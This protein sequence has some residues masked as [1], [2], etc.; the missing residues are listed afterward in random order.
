ML[1]TEQLMVTVDF[2]TMEVSGHGQLFGYQLLQV[3]NNLRVNL[4][5]L[6]F[7]IFNTILS[8]SLTANRKQQ[9]IKL[10][11]SHGV[12]LDWVIGN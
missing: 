12:K 7:I 11:A 5:K 10:K 8:K 2:C 1:T 9:K 4:I 3:W 6:F